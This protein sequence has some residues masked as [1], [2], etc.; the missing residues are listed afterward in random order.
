MASRAVDGIHWRPFVASAG[1]LKVDLP[2]D[3]TERNAIVKTS[4]G[5]MKVHGFHSMHN[6]ILYVAAYSECHARLSV[7]EYVKVRDG[8]LDEWVRGARRR[9]P[10]GERLVVGGGPRG[11]REDDFAL[12]TRKEGGKLIARRRWMERQ[13]CFYQAIVVLPETLAGAASVA[14]FFESLEPVPIAVDR[15]GLTPAWTRHMARDEGFTALW[16][17]R[18]DDPLI[19]VVMTP[20]RSAAYQTY[21]VF[22]RSMGFSVTVI[23]Y[24]PPTILYPG[25]LRIEAAEVMDDVRDRFLSDYDAVLLT[26]RPIRLGELAGREFEA[27]FTVTTRLEDGSRRHPPGPG[28]EHVKARLYASGNR[29]FLVYVTTPAGLKSHK[30]IE[31]FL[32]SFQLLEA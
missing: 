10:L 16:P 23:H 24:R 28:V 22:K 25:E 2:S 5:R 9:K 6:G 17:E 15:R 11:P 26:E 32:D 7:H 31:T 4:R 14:R 27:K 13:G 8:P 29:A 20:T 21:F 19:R 12:P 30:G 1:G 3:P 18:F